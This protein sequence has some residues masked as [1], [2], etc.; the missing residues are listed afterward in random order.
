MFRSALA[1]LM[2]VPMVGPL[3]GNQQ[4]SPTIQERVGRI[5]KGSVIEV[6]TKLKTTEKV[7]GRLGEVN[8]EGFELQI[9]QG[10]RWITSN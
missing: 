6:K 8:A 5:T 9:T 7:T 1:V 10:R 2:V 4:T 3:R